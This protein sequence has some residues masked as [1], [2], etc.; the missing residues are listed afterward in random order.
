MAEHLTGTVVAEKYRLD[1]LLR[2]GE[3]G[4]FYRGRHLFMDKPV[5][6][7]VLPP[8]LA[9]DDSIR[10]QFTAEA[11][12]A[13][14]LSNQHILAANDFGSNSDGSHYVVYEGFDG[15]PLKNSVGVGGQFSPDRAAAIARQIA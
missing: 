9:V 13:S 10:D 15:E 11:R 6:L 8:S 12:S 4:D 1:S 5:T 14:A 2:S 3:V 7:K